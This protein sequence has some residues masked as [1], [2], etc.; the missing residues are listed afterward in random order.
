MAITHNLSIKVSGTEA[1]GRPAFSVF[2]NGVAVAT[3]VEVGA[4]YRLGQWN[5]FTF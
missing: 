1:S 2:V 4:D 3:N 5:T